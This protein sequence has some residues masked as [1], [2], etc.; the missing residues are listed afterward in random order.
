MGNTKPRLRKGQHMKENTIIHLQDK[1]HDLKLFYSGTIELM[2]K[3]ERRHIHTISEL[4]EA[5][6]A[7]KV[8][9]DKFYN[10]IQRLK[11]WRSPIE[12]FLSKL[13]R[14]R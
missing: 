11:R 13:R 5:L 10:E 7:Q 2:Q 6:Q 1:I 12:W 4:T 9:L 3:Q 14:N 8:T